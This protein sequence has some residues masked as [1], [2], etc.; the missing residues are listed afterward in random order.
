MCGI[1][2]FIDFERNNKKLILKKML[3]ELKHRGPDD[4]GMWFNDFLSLGHR[5]LSV[6]D[7]S[8]RG[9]QPMISRSGRYVCSFNGEI[10]N[11]KELKQKLEK[12]SYE[13]N[14]S[15][16]T[17]VLLALIEDVG[18]SNALK[19]CIG[20]FA[21]ALWDKNN[22]NLHIARD[23][24]GEKSIYYGWSNKRFF[25]SSELKSIVKH[26]HFKKN[27]NQE[28][29]NLML[30]SN[31]IPA[32]YSI[33][34][35]V[36]KLEPGNIFT[37]DIDYRKHQLSNYSI[38]NY[39]SL[40]SQFS[41]CNNNKFK[42]SFR[43]ASNI[44]EELLED[45]IVKQ[46]RSDVPLGMMLSGGIDSSLICSLAQKS[47]SQVIKTFTVGFD[48][49]ALNE[50]EFARAISSHLGTE[51]HDMV[52]SGYD[53]YKFVP[54]LA[55]IYDEPFSDISQIP[56]YFVSKF[57]GEKVSVALSGDGADELFLGYSRHLL[58]L[59]LSKIPYSNFIA[60]VLDN[61]MVRVVFN[62]LSAGKK[63]NSY[64]YFVSL[65]GSKD[66]LE[67]I[68]KLSRD[69]FAPN[70][71]N[72]Y[73]TPD[74][75]FNNDIPSNLI[76]NI[77]DLFRY[78]DIKDFLSNDIMLKVDRSSMASSLE[79]RSPFLDHRIL[80]F[81]SKLPSNYLHNFR[82]SKLLLKSILY[83]YIPKNLVERPKMGFIPPIAYWLRTDLKEWA[84]DQLV[85][86][87]SELNL[88]DLKKSKELFHSHI[89]QKQDNSLL[90]WRILMLQAWKKRWL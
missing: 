37:L 32:P 44:I 66:N 53:A 3:N 18:L 17:E 34:K 10:Y 20:M 47:T 87:N 29:V 19:D 25:F 89:N 79:M 69:R 73:F 63:M 11:Y 36:Y 49:R 67:M 88:V 6:I 76:N 5:R 78:I 70:Y 84:G 41:D 86:T 23:R 52:V 64:D 45:A 28:A 14:G 4:E 75:I 24:F 22:D 60:S 77:V 54:E 74:N 8:D 80:E 65:L 1:S 2:G 82:G 21:I 62:C 58:G 40:E 13:F 61:Q 9:A 85:D 30:C 46:S 81:I 15:S 35:D 57:A 16:D 55:E 68:G 48:S 33:Y 31:F 90:L 7:T 42:G 72:N 56:S 43:E 51:H 39:W 71:L 26:P 27:I 12:K 38:T 59:Y 83:K 50:I